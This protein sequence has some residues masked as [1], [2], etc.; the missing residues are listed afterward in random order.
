MSMRANISTAYARCTDESF[1]SASSR[2]RSRALS[3]S[4]ITSS[5]VPG[6]RGPPGEDETL[7]R[8]RVTACAANA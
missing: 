5:S 2:A 3:D 1:G 7:S 6:A 4:A 8:S